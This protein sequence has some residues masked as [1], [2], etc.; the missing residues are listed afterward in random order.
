MPQELDLSAFDGI[1]LRVKGDGQTFKLNI[2]TV[3]RACPGS[4]CGAAACPPACQGIG[5]CPACPPACR[6]MP[7][8]CVPACLPGSQ[9]YS[10]LSCLWPALHPPAQDM[11]TEKPED[12]YQATFETQVGRGQ[13]V[14]LFHGIPWNSWPWEFF[15]CGVQGNS[16]EFRLL[17]NVSNGSFQG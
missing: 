12:T 4:S 5:I 16:V 6:C 14:L 13:S 17:L 7:S 15:F 10:L 1:S 11:Q 2:K 9:S 8:S 3:G